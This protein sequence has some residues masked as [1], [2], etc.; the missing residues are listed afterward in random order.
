MLNFSLLSLLLVILCPSADAQIID[1]KTGDEISVEDLVRRVRDADMLLL[2]EFHDNVFHH[3]ERGVLIKLLA[4]PA[5][6]VISEHLP[7]ESRVNFSGSTLSALELAGFDKKAWDWPLHASLFDAIR[8]TGNTLVGGN[9]AK[10]VSK[11]LAKN[12]RNILTRKMDEAIERAT[13]NVQSR[14]ALDQDLIDGHC[15][16]LPEKYLPPMQLIQRATDS[17]FALSMLENK[18]AILIAGNGHVRKDYGVPQVINSIAPEMKI[19]SIGFHERS[20]SEVNQTPSFNGLYDFVW[21]TEAASRPD[22]CAGFK[23]K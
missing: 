16:Q 20:N 13:L 17:S 11:D 15:G 2:G 9:L 8:L 18:P 22:P 23:L 1:V 4:L 6:T 10:G 21:L 19:I 12:G 7:A 5:M 14:Q 3:R